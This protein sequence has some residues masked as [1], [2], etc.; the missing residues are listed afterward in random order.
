[1]EEH[2]WRQRRARRPAFALDVL[3]GRIPASKW[4]RLTCERHLKELAR[5]KRT[6]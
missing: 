3:E 2:A 4:V 6:H 1:M 5:A